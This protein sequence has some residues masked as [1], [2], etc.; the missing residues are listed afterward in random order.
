MNIWLNKNI[1]FD[2]K[3]HIEILF[4]LWELIL[5][6]DKKLLKS[7]LINMIINNSYSIVNTIIKLKNTYNLDNKSNLLSDVNACNYSEI[8]DKQPAIDLSS[9]SFDYPHFSR[10]S[11]SLS[12]LSYL[13]F[14]YPHFSPVPQSFSLEKEDKGDY[15]LN[16][17]S[18][19]EFGSNN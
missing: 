16:L 15:T 6:I 17:N 19:I 4:S 11:Q 8:Y 2:D 10:V 9:L 7:D 3:V 5:K 14:D 1:F 18:D 13:S 12:S